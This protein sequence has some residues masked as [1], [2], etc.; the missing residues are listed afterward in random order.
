MNTPAKW[1][2]NDIATSICSNMPDMV[3]PSSYK[4]LENNDSM[5]PKGNRSNDT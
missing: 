3:Q 5:K 2:G 4:N 1:K